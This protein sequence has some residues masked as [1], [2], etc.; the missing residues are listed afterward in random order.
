MFHL[1][2]PYLQPTDNMIV[3]QMYGNS[4]SVGF[5]GGFNYIDNVS[6]VTVF[7]L[8]LLQESIKYVIKYVTFLKNYLC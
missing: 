3:Y 6:A 7:L 4:Q 1:L 5:F 8:S 2:F